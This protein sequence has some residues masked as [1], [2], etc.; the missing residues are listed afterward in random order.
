MSSKNKNKHHHEPVP[1]KK[2]SQIPLIIG[3]IVVVCIIIALVVILRKPDSVPA[4]QSPLQATKTA[5]T[6]EMK[7]K[8]F[9][10]AEAVTSLFHVVYTPCWEGAY[11]AIG[12][13]YLFA[14]TKD[15]T[16]LRFHLF[17]HDLKRMCIGTWVDDRAWVCLAEYAWWNVTGK[18][19]NALIVDARGR[20]IEAKNEG[21]LSNHEGFWSWYNWSPKHR[22][23][24]RIFTNGAINQMATVA[25]DLYDATGEKQFLDDAL[26][27]WNGDKKTPG[28]EKTL[29]RGNGVWEGKSGR[30]AFGKQIAWNGA[31]YCALGA[32]LYRVTKDNKYKKIVV[33]TVQ[34]IMNPTNGWVDAQ[35]YYQIS[36]DG[37]G[38]FVNFILDAYAIAP[39]ELHD[40]LPKI[41]KMLEHVWTNNN[42]TA[43]VKLH[44][45][46][47]NG[48][49]NG[50]NP[51]GGE[52][53]YNV[54]EVGS[55]H[56]QGE[57]ARA[58]GVFAYYQSKAS[59]S[60]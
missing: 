38:A 5:H 50:W 7:N 40:L 18:Q 34:R 21:R 23:N 12:D 53:G 19:Y 48:I 37:N 20:Y 14:A 6:Q 45:D 10:R 43:T 24:E 16:L 56:A 58:F 3:S 46:T 8:W 49:R 44:R 52:D 28:I 11:G 36:M 15:S 13:A 54:D 26:L 57:A 31:E 41:E 30:A 33:E 59:G 55:V 35:D 4:E 29:Y 42:G 39:D 22:V 1:P 2:K 25:C 32:A 9:E 17:D 47:D 51:H 60:K 27:V